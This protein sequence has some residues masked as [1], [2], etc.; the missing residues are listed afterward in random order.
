MQLTDLSVTHNLQSIVELFIVYLG[1][2]LIATMKNS[3]S[4]V[5]KVAL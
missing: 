2:L 4:H 1:W 5:M 3:T